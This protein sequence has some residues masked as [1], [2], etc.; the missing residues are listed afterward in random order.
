[1]ISIKESIGILCYLLKLKIE[2]YGVFLNFFEYVKNKD[3]CNVFFI[4]RYRILFFKIFDLFLNIL[5]F[6]FYFSDIDFII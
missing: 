3:M 1:M 2:M 5:G 4:F 6:L